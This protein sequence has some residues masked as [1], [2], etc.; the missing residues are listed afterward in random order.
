MPSW[1]GLAFHTTDH[2]NR[3]STCGFPTQR[4]V[5]RNC[6][7]ALMLAW[8]SCWTSIHMTGDLR[9]HEA[10]VTSLCCTNMYPKRVASYVIMRQAR[11]RF[12]VV[13][14]IWQ[15]Q[16]QV[17]GWLFQVNII[18]DV[19][20]WF[21]VRYNSYIVFEHAHGFNFQACQCWLDIE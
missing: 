7:I 18:A 11:Q 14:P 16:R 20:W 5:V 15:A 21:H 2:W 12:G 9:R 6:N 1:H 19:M 17:G 13:L 3:E 4:P 10:N 8:T